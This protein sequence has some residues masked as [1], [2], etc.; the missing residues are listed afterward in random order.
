MLWELNSDDP[1]EDYLVV[2]QSLSHV[3]LLETPW[4]AACQASLSFTISQS[5]VKLMSTKWL[6]MPSILLIPCCSCLLLP[7]VFPSSRVLQWVLELP[8]YWSFSF[9][10]SPSSEYSGLILTGLI[11]LLSKGVS[12]VF[13]STTV[14][15]HCVWSIAHVQ[16]I[17]LLLL[18]CHWRCLFLVGSLISTKHHH[19]QPQSKTHYQ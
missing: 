17:L 8:K 9:S 1:Q 14:Q 10:T 4:I 13:S 6:V 18:L 5:L 3:R 11:S 19:H 7:S 15:K 16:K 12:R 2:V